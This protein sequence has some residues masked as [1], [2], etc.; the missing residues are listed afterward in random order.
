MYD[1]FSPTAVRID[2]DRFFNPD[3]KRTRITGRKLISLDELNK[4]ELITVG[5][6]QQQSRS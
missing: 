2:Y 1:A 4:P 5:Q 3:D 6:F